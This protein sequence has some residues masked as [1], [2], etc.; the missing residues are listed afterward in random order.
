ME[1]VYII[2]IRSVRLLQH[3]TNAYTKSMPSK[4][5]YCN[6]PGHR[7]YECLQRKGINLTTKFT[8]ANNLKEITKYEEPKGKEIFVTKD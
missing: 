7:L 5:Y 4:Y 2:Y 3:N 6:Q 8:K 1:S